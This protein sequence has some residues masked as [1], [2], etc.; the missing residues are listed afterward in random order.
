MDAEAL[1]IYA[2]SY[3]RAV[4]MVRVTALSLPAET[5]AAAVAAVENALA[6]GDLDALRQQLR[7]MLT[8][9]RSP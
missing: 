8:C 7:E 5:L 4:E 2:A 6:T 9:A 1:Q 3:P